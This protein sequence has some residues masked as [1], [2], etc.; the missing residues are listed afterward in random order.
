MQRV[1]KK[2]TFAHAVNSPFPLLEMTP[3]RIWPRSFGH[4]PPPGMVMSWRVWLFRSLVCTLCAAVAVIGWLAYAQTNSE[5]VRTK[6]IEQMQAGFPG[7]EVQS[8][9]AWVRPLGGLWLRDVRLSRREDPSHPFLV[10]PS[11]T[12]YH[13]KEQLA[14]GRLVIRKVEL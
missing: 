9:S 2:R 5:A 8:G 4:L 11:A 10:V 13:D 14:Q 7:V 6:G 1:S 12:I 3:Q